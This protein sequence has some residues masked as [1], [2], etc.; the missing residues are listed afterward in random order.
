M[1]PQT[2]ARHEPPGRAPPLTRKRNVILRSHSCHF[3]TT[4]PG[5]RWCTN[6]KYYARN[7]GVNWRTETRGVMRET[8]VEERRVVV[9]VG[10]RGICSLCGGELLP[11]QAV[12]LDSG[13]YDSTKVGDDWTW[14]HETCVVVQMRPV[15]ESATR[16]R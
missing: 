9:A 2:W 8:I 7:V 16:T 14:H 6:S 1:L 15:P 3:C 11:G 12:S 5:L 4:F 13:P 10:S